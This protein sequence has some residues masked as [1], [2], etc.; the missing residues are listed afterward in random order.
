MPE[1]ISQKQAAGISSLRIISREAMKVLIPSLS[2]FLCSD[3][4][5]TRESEEEPAN[6]LVNVNCAMETFS[7]QNIVQAI[8]LLSLQS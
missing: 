4:F 8:L 2:E 1:R 5:L 7:V 6:P 3:T